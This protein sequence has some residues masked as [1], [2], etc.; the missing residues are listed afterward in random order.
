MKTTYKNR[1]GDLIQF[2]Q[3]DDNTV[4][5][6]GYLN[7][8]L[9][10]GY[11]NDYTDAYEAYLLDVGRKEEAP[12]MGLDYISL[13]DFSHKIH[14]YKEG[15]ENTLKKYRELVKSTNDIWF[16]DGSGGPFISKKTNLNLYYNDGIDR[17]VTNI[18]VDKDKIIFKINE[19]NSTEDN[20][21]K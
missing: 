1:Y 8:G 21:R 3:I 5:M 7:L 16:V 14:D 6:S 4:E 9:R 15:E 18:S 19:G 20:K 17:I 2:N 13:E 12:I 10:C 11:E